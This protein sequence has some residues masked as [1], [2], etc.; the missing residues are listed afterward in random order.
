MRA[1]SVPL[2]TMGQDEAVTV[3]P[4]ESIL[5]LNV[6][7]PRSDGII[8]R[9]MELHRR[10][11]SSERTCLITIPTYGGKGGHPII[12]STSL[13]D[14]LMDISED[15]LGVKDVV[16]RHG[17]ETQ[18]IEVDSPEILLDL[19]TPQDYRK[20]LEMPSAHALTKEQRLLQ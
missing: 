19:N 17:E 20:A 9:V 11:N 15:T 6:D 12:L 2:A 13:V 8:R 7:Q 14:E 3:L 4:E 5:I 18:R 1:S 10:A 16:R